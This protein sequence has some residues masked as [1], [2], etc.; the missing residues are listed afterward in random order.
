[1]A[2]ET[3]PA[4]KSVPKPGLYRHPSGAEVVLSESPGIGTPMLDAFIQQGYVRVEEERKVAPRDEEKAV[5]PT[6][7]ELREQLVGLGA[8]PKVVKTLKK[9][10]LQDMLISMKVK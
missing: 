4:G 1:M 7:K 8:D 5:E 3:N 9:S 6:N 10:D 2:V